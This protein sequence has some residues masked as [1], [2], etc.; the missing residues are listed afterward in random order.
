[1]QLSSVS[2]LSCGASF[3]VASSFDSG[4]VSIFIDITFCTIIAR[5]FAV[6]LECYLFIFMFS[7]SQECPSCHAVVDRS[8]VSIE[9]LPT[10]FGHQLSTAIL[11]KPSDGSWNTYRFS[12]LKRIRS[13][14]FP[15]EDN[16][17]YLIDLVDFLN[18]FSVSNSVTIST[19]E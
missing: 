13:V 14:Y 4:S 9:K 16:C 15:S 2:H 6:F 12:P 5:V 18:P 17:F 3:L 10:P 19:S 1:M 11:L 8:D 7:S